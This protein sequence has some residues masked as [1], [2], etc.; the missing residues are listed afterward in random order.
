MLSVLLTIALSA[1]APTEV[2]ARP[3]ANLQRPVWSPDG[4]QLAYEANDHAS[5]RIDLYAGDPDTRAFQ[6]VTAGTR[7]M[8]SASAGFSNASSAST[9]VHE[10]SWSPPSIGRFVYSATNDMSDYD[11][12]IAGGSAVAPGPGADGGA[13]WSADG[14]WIAFTSARTGQGDLYLIDVNAIEKPPRQLTS[15]P[16]SA[17]LYATWSN[18]GSKLAW[19]GHSDATGD[20]VW[21]LPALDGTPI[22]LTKL[23]GAQSR[24]SFS[25]NG[26]LVAFYATADGER[27]DLY[28]TQAQD[29]STPRLLQ[30]GVLPN[31][32]G[33]A[34]LPDGNG[35]VTVLDDDE[36]FDPI[37]VV[38]LAG[39]D[40]RVLDLGTVG[41]GDLDVAAG[42]KG[43]RLAYVAQ[44]R[45]TDT[46]RDF[47]RL[48]VTELP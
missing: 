29:G 23:P 13:A 32:T 24:P 10:L 6:K 33:P 36:R 8:S 21:L 15:D 25:P 5:K 42:P 22:R 16:A 9:V 34:W 12:Y 27:W 26:N 20:N 28:V 47:K 48:F 30:Q 31:A 17:E 38:P 3:D 11:L 39:G 41:H 40:P 43:T 4:K 18:H 14:R 37:A 19:V 46:R 2:A 44:G 45:A 35:L 1:A 7:S